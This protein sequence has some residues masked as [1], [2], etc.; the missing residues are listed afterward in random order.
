[1][2]S[3]PAFG[4][5]SH[6]VQPAPPARPDAGDREVLWWWLYTDRPTDP[7]SDED[8]VSEGEEKQLQYAG[9]AQNQPAAYESAS[10]IHISQVLMSIQTRRRH[11]Y[12]DT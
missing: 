7:Q 10:E 11:E 3:F 9:R 2:F 8:Q 5:V 4:F 6:T 1:M 12:S